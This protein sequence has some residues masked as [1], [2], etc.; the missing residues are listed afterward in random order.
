MFKG[1]V[2]G[3]NELVCH[4]GSQFELWSFPT[5]PHLSTVSEVELHPMEVDFNS[6]MF[7]DSC[8]NFGANKG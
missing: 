3:M 4:F 5:H 2:G 1:G 7:N 8:G 6:E